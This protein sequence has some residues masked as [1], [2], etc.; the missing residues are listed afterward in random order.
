M[1]TIVR[2]GPGDCRRMPWRNGGGTTT[3]ISAEP[4]GPGKFLWRLSIAEVAA[5]GPFSDFTGYD[6]HILLLAGRGLVLHFAEAPSR[7]LHRPLDPFSFDG[8]WRASCELVDGPVRDLN[9]MVARG[10]AEGALEV[11]RIPAGS[12]VELPPARTL[13]LHLL[14]GAVEAGGIRLAAGDTLR[15]DEA[16]G[17]RV[18]LAAAED[19]VAVLATILPA[20][21][22]V[23]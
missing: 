17:T 19:A 11:L 4:A 20:R 7:A 15:A 22:G 23:H 21:E 13:L 18:A 9:L 6:R 1:A 8:G 14:E 12:R 2:I 3:E 5:S 16:G 10:A